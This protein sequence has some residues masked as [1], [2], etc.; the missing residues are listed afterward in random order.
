MDDDQALA[1][2]G[3]VLTDKQPLQVNIRIQEAWLIV[4]AIQLASRHPGIGEAQRGALID[5]AE[6]IAAPIIERHP[7][8]ASV[9]E[10]G[11]DPTHD[12]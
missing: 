2:I 9:I 4:S 12:G 8:A 3:A 7:D 11:W 10:M 6:Q 1:I 5:I